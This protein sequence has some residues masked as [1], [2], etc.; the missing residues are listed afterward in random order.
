[1]SGHRDV[2]IPATK[3]FRLG[4]L[5]EGLHV[6]LAS[7]H[8]EVAVK[9]WRKKGP[10]GHVKD[11]WL[12]TGALPSAPTSSQMAFGETNHDEVCK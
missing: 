6:W 10:G 4:M 11:A 12:Y 3:M 8:P 7:A 2:N 1:M 9:G 5:L